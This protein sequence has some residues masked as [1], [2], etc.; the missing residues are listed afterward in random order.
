MDLFIQKTTNTPL[1]SFDN[2][3]LVISGRSIP[4]NAITFFE[5]LFKSIADYT[6]TPCNSTEVS[7]L[8]EY[9][10][11]STNRSLMTVFTLLEKLYENG[12]ELIV[13]WYYENG[14][15]LMFELGN[16]YKALL[17]IP[18]AIEEKEFTD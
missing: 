13:K 10:N 15:D 7:V 1:I 8:L 14:D 4:E 12:N 5:P 3:I 2:G 6:K 16:D 9:C 17:S 18:F 11:S